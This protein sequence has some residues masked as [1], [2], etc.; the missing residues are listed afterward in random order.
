[1]QSAEDKNR[2]TKHPLTAPQQQPASIARVL[3]VLASV[4]VVCAGMYVAAGPILNPIFFA[5]TLAL[6]FSPIYG[7]LRRRLPTLLALLIIM[8]GLVA[9][10]FGLVMLLSTSL[11]RFTAELSYYAAQ[12]DDQLA[13]LQARLNEL[14]LATVDLSSVFNPSVMATFLGTIAGAIL[15]FLGDLFL[16]LVLVLF[17][18]AEGPAIMRRLQASVEGE[19]PRIERLFDVGKGVTRQFALRA[20]VNLATGA[21]VILLLLVVGVPYPVLWGVLTFFLSYVPYIGITV[22]MIPPT[23][24]ALA[25]SGP[26]WTIV[27][28]VGVVVI[29]LLAENALSPYLMG[30]GLNLSPTVVFF[31]FIFWVF[32]LGAPGAFLAMPLTLFLVVML[33][34]YPEASWLVSLMVAQVPTSEEVSAT[35]TGGSTA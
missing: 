17:F 30:R 12:W 14:G 29:N 26:G 33:S 25:E 15:G 18:L 34:T 16:I 22:A 11:S 9:L 13:Q 1:L 31:S 35:D 7:W 28:I 20:V 10:T 4:V 2:E 32:L 21:G 19:H 6:I 23:L 27:V 5:L 3:V 8:I 24:L